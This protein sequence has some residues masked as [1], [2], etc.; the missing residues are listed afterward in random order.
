MNDIEGPPRDL[1]QWRVHCPSCK[2][3]GIMAFRHLLSGKPVPPE[4]FTCPDCH[5]K[6][7]ILGRHDQ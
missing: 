2:R 4:E 6:V 5:V 7:E 3:D 1:P